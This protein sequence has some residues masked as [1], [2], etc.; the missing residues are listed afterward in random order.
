M[1][2]LVD[3]MIFMWTLPDLMKKF[4][5]FEKQKDFFFVQNLWDPRNAMFAEYKLFPC[6]QITIITPVILGVFTLINYTYVY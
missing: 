3:C 6:T 5:S 1:L 4:M 2:V